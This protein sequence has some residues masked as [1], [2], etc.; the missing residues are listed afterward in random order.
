MAKSQPPYTG[1][2]SNIRDRVLGKVEKNSF[3]ALPGKRDPSR[4]LPSQTMCCNPGGFDRE[5]YKK[6]LAMNGVAERTRGC[7]GS[8]MVKCPN[9]HSPVPLILPQVVP[10][11]LLS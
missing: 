5:F 6:I 11:L 7:E 4:L 3:T 9:L 2:K 10:W 1:A 8:Q